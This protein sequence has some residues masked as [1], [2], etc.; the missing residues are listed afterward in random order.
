M[1]TEKIFTLFKNAG[2]NVE[3]S[4]KNVIVSLNNRTV[5]MQE[6]QMV[7]GDRRNTLTKIGS[8]VQI[9]PMTIS[10]R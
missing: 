2:F 3:L 6:A 9:S 1:T 4:G 8:T 5:D 7:L 10:I